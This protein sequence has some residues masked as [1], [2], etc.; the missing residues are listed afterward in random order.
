MH[1][2]ALYKKTEV[3]RE[4]ASR[5]IDKAEEITSRILFSTQRGPYS[6]AGCESWTSMKIILEA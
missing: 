1:N 3:K 6:E 4:N 2:G 5:W